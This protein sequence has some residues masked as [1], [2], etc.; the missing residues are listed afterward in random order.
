MK[1]EK[2][3]SLFILLFAFGFLFINLYHVQAE[4]YGLEETMGVGNLSSAFNKSEVDTRQPGGFLSFKSGQ[5]VGS[6]LSFIGVVFMVLIIYAGLSWMISGGNESRVEKSKNLMVAAVIGLVIVLSAY[7]ITAFI[8]RE[9]TV[10][11]PL[12]GVK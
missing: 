10:T 5:I 2:I 3:I 7:A 1:K 6:L 11:A 9:I 8:G 12:G 4:D